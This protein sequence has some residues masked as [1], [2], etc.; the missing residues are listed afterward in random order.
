M[1]YNATPHDR[2]RNKELDGLEG[3]KL[4]LKMIEMLWMLLDDIDT[5]DDACRGD[6]ARFRKRAYQIQ[7]KR[8]DI[9]GSDGYRLIMK[10]R[11]PK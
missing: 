6:D 5:L 2:I 3:E 9:I 10:D 1:N 8:H 4:H 11:N 7:Q